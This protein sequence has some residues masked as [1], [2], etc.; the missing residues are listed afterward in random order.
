[1]RIN[2]RS[3]F[4]I[5]GL[6]GKENLEIDRVEISLREF[7][8]ELSRR[9]PIRVEYIR[10]GIIDPDEWEIEINNIPYYAC[11]G[12]LDTLLRDNDTVTIK[13]MALGGG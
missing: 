3:N 1:M 13:I 11:P 4:V 7:L 12:G 5:P 6:E 10:Q 2:I 8:E 9:A